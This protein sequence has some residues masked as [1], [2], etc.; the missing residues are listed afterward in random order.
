MLATLAVAFALV[1]GARVA[2][3]QPDTAH[4][5]DAGRFT[6]VA[7]A[8]DLPLA[9]NLLAQAQRTDTFPGLARPRA[10]VVIASSS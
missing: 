8:R 10:K 6:M 1:F 7:W 4:R 9:R 3:A 5:I 2:D